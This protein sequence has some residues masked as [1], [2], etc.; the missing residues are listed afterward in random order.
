MRYFLP[1]WED[2]LDPNYNFENDEFSRDKSIAYD[3]D[4]YAHQIFK[5]P[6]Y[7]GILV[8]L[9]IFKN[10]INLNSDINGQRQVRTYGSIKEYLKIHPK[11]KL[12]VMGDC[13]AFS[14]I[15]EEIPPDDY[16]TEKVAETYQSLRFDYG[17]SVDHMIPDIIVKKVDGNK[18]IKIPLTD[19]QKEQRRQ[20][21]ISNAKDF[22]KY[23]RKKN[24]NFIPIGAVQGYSPETYADSTARLIEM[25]YSY[26]G[27]GTLVP[28]SDDEIVEI[29]KRV[30]K[31]IAKKN[32]KIHLFGILRPQIIKEF[33][34]LGVS[35]L[36]SA[37]FLRKA[38]LRAGR[39]YIT[40]N[41]DWY[42]AIRVPYS[43][44]PVLIKNALKEGYS[45]DKVIEMETKALKVLR[46]Y[47]DRKTK[48][49]EEVLNTILEYDKL[50]LREYDGNHHY[51]K[52]R[53]TLMDRPWEKCNCEIC[54]KIG[55]E[56]IIFRGSNRNKR[57]G[58]HNIK[59]FYDFILKNK[60]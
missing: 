16:H 35:S 60:S 31:V 19:Q 48:N 32:I 44:N 10:K 29:L 45:I 36:D 50:L 18:K 28:K 33:K 7:D 26:I 25:G 9:A 55:V 30:K 54:R 56:V 49:I 21:S 57:R 47:A 1:D 8:S 12:E 42:A 58:F 37:S 15:N 27:I 22:I 3:T 46:D 51:D 11:S 17:V 38:W 4:I 13:G 40:K 39:N 34:S 59:I 53:K 14:Y 2:R 43:D 5:K 23:H 24:L 20:L 41:G 6:P 52:Y